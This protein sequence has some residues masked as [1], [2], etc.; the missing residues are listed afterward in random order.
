MK[1]IPIEAFETEVVNEGS[2]EANFDVELFDGGCG[3]FL[4]SNEGVGE[5]LIQVLGSMRFGGR[6]RI[7]EFQ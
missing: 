6:A 5:V 2:D 3:I 4:H 1:L 7:F